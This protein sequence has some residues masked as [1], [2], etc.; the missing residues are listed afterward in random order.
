MEFD[1]QKRRGPGSVGALPEA[2]N[3]NTRIRNSTALSSYRA[4]AGN[5]RPAIQTPRPVR[6]P[7]NW[8]E[9]LPHPAAYYAAHLANVSRADGKGWVACRCPFHDDQHAS[10]SANLLTGGFRCHACEARGD[11]VGFHMR[12]TGLAFAPAVRDLIGGAR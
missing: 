2:E 4:L 11:L 7:A 1:R 8:R 10:A 9:R 5:G 3:R 6:L 12:R